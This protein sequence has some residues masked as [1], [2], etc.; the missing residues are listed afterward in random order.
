M[1]LFYG[2]QPVV[3]NT[4]SGNE[5]GHVEKSVQVIRDRAFTKIYEFSS[6]DH[7]QEYLTSALTK[8]NQGTT[9]ATERTQLK[10]IG[11]RL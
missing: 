7:A 5:K 4:Y 9:I 1:S 11:F 8:L 6:I 2:F 10:T 3:T